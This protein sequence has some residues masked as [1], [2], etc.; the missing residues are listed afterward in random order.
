LPSLLLLFTLTLLPQPD[1]HNP[2]NENPNTTTK[3]DELIPIAFR[4]RHHIADFLSRDEATDF[5]IKLQEATGNAPKG[6]SA[7]Y[8]RERNGD[9]DEKKID[10]SNSG[11]QLLQKMGW[12]EGEGLGV[13]GSGEKEIITTKFKNDKIG[14]GADKVT[15]EEDIFEV[16][17][18]KMSQAYK[19][20]PNPYKNNRAA[21]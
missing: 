12:K 10:T 6:A 3:E 8:W 17:K 20:R 21:Y 1:P 7:A 16:Y 9:G 14:I 15:G 5:Y 2:K 18:K 11:Y 19:Q 4:E 13:N